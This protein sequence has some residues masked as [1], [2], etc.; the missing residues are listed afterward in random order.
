MSSYDHSSPF[1]E[2]SPAGP[3]ALEHSSPF[4]EHSN[5]NNQSFETT[6]SSLATASK[7]HDFFETDKY[8]AAH[9]ATQPHQSPI[10]QFLEELE[11]AVS[12]EP[13]S[14]GASSTHT[15]PHSPVDAKLPDGLPV[16][17]AEEFTIDNPSTL[18]KVDQQTQ[19]N[20]HSSPTL[21]SASEGRSSHPWSTPPSSPVVKDTSFFDFEAAIATTYESTS[22]MAAMDVSMFCDVDGGDYFTNGNGDMFSSTHETKMTWLDEL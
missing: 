8:E 2:S 6:L 20:M 21:V 1:E 4:D 15:P 16:P 19:D 5:G 3:G 9:E 22:S 14:V 13:P 18:S 17:E 12:A 7:S 11:R 10:E